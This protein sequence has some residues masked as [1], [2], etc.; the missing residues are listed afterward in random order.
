MAGN[1]YLLTFIYFVPTRDSAINNSGRPAEQTLESIFSSP[2]L[3]IFPL[4]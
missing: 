4:Q 2:R 1:H 3:R